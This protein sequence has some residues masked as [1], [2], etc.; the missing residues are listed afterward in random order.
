MNGLETAKVAYFA[1]F[2][3]HQR[4]SI[5]AWGVT[6]GNSLEQVIIQ[7]LEFLNEH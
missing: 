2:E 7:Q 5:A 6:T 3:S 4:Y 1:H